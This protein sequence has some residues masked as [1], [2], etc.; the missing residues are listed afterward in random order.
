MRLHRGACPEHSGWSRALSFCVCE[1][2]RTS[3]DSGGFEDPLRRHEPRAV[4]RFYA[5]ISHGHDFPSPTGLDGLGEAL[6]RFL[7]P[8]STFMSQ[9]N[10]STAGELPGLSDLARWHTK[11]NHSGG[12]QAG[13]GDGLPDSTGV[14]LPLAAALPLGRNTQSHP[15][16]RYSNEP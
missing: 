15:P 11:L 1:V 9:Q 14:D 2:E 12:A 5:T 7:P 13:E 10:D 3:G 16:F 4:F 6:R 8:S